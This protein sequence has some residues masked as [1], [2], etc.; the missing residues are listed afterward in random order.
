MSQRFLLLC[1]LFPVRV[2]QGCVLRKLLVSREEDCKWPLGSGLVAWPSW[3]AASC[4][5][6]L[7][8]D[9]DT[10]PPLP[11]GEMGSASSR[12]RKGAVGLVILWHVGTGAAGSGGPWVVAAGGRGRA[13]KVRQGEALRASTVAGGGCAAC[14]GGSLGRVRGLPV[15]HVGRF[16]GHLHAQVGTE[17]GFPPQS[18]ACPL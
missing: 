18:C 6:V 17:C 9:L 14:P 13:C 3:H 16:P 4:E 12:S 8:L 11:A 15:P 1:W 7:V 10:G 2:P 5:L